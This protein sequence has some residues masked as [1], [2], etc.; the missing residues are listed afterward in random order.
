MKG[1]IYKTK[2]FLSNGKIITHE[3][4]RDKLIKEWRRNEELS[5]QEIVKSLK[6]GRGKYKEIS[7]IKME[8]YDWANNLTISKVFDEGE[9]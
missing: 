1:K 6:L 2:F 3:E 9:M 4:K 8:F 7:L 5:S